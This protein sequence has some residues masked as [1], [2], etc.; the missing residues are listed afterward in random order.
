MQLCAYKMQVVQEYFCVNSYIEIYTTGYS[1]VP[2]TWDSGT[3]QGMH[4]GLA[5]LYS[6][7]VAVV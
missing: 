7:G 5:V 1:H 3:M 6:R 2:A 4:P